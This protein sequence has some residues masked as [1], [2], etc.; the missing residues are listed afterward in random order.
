MLDLAAGAAD[1]LKDVVDMVEELSLT[2]P[3]FKAYEDD[4][5]MDR[6]LET[7]LVDVYAEVICFYA[8]C[9]HF[10]RIHPH[11]LLRRNDWEEFRSDFARTLLRIRRLSSIVESEA[12]SA[13]MKHEREKYNEVLHM[14]ETFKGARLKEEE[15][16]HYHYIPSELSPRFWGREDALK[17]IGDVLSPK[18]KPHG[19]RTFALHGMGGVG[20]TQIALQ[21]ANR[22]RDQYQVIMW[23]A[24]DNVISIGQSLRDIAKLLGFVQSE[25][26]LQDTIAATMKVKG[27]L[28]DTSKP[29]FTFNHLVRRTLLQD[30]CP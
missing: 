3:R 7:A 2:L 16:V 24:A 10:F 14:M 23:I 15:V 6:P 5:Y 12:E 30:I 4:L 1:T 22:N 27:W 29:M 18:V 20:K 25:Q 26:E 9:I 11:V 19:L 21:Y 8:R 17:A 28:N 13:R